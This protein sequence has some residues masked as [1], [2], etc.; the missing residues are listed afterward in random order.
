MQSAIA[1]SNENS[2]DGIKIYILSKMKEIND[3]EQSSTL[4]Q[5][6]D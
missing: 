1:V 2:S 6:E 5:V 3:K 4:P